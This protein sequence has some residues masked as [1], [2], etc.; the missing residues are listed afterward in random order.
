MTFPRSN[1]L[2]GGGDRELDKL[3]FFGLADGTDDSPGVA[4]AS[5]LAA[6][7]VRWTANMYDLD[8][9]AFVT[10]VC[11]RC[12]STLI[13]ALAGHSSHLQGPRAL[14]SA[15]RFAAQMTSCNI[16]GNPRS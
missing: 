11:P 16:V 15:A 12:L 5:P 13:H 3:P 8:A 1:G 2:G 4:G 7:S 6:C 9:K 10:A 14:G